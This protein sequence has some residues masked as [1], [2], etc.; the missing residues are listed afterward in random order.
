M[1]KKSPWKKQKITDLI[2]MSWG[3]S[4]LM[5]SASII[6]VAGTPIYG[7]NCQVDGSGN[8]QK[9]DVGIIGYYGTN[10]TYRNYLFIQTGIEGAGAESLAVRRAW[11]SQEFI[12]ASITYYADE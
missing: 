8:P 6:R 5:Y 12:N 9:K 10:T 4:G 11:I 1:Q 7:E 2:W 3:S